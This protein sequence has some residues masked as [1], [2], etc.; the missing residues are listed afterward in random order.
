MP[1]RTGLRLLFAAVIGLA[2]LGAGYGFV[3]GQATPTFEDHLDAQG[4]MDGDQPVAPPSDGI[5]VITTDSNSW[6]GEQSDGPRARANIVA[7]NPDGTVL[8]Y[9]D[10]HTRYWDVE[11]VQGTQA[12]V[13]YAYADHLEAADCPTDWDHTAFGVD[14]EVWDEYYEFHGNVEACTRNGVDRVNLTTGEVTHVWSTITPGK[15]NSRYHDVDRL[16]DERL[17]V[18]DIYFD[19]VFIVNTETDRIEWTWNASDDFSTDSGG[20]H[21]KDWTHINDV[22]VLDDGRLMV[23][24]RN[25]DQVVFLDRERG[26]LEEWTLGA[27]DDHATLYEQHNPD[28]IPPED[29]GP[30]VVI[31][32]SES[33]RVVE[34]QRTDD[35]GW[36]KTWV[37][38]DVRMQ[39]PRDAA[40][41]S[42][43]HTLITDSNGNRVFEVDRS[44]EVVWS[45][46]IAFPYEAERI[47]PGAT[48]A[49]GPS[50]TSAGIESS[51][52]SF[53]DWA[54]IGIKNALPGKHLN[55]LMYATPVWMGLLEVLALA[56]AGLT[57]VLWLVAEGYWRLVGRRNAAAR[58]SEAD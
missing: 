28:Y 37:W 12:T 35:G 48:K 22:D 51:T 2:L 10:T 1:S 7:F 49:G 39:W 47:G 23:S 15:P 46:N 58:T 16:D 42:N 40:R 11:H 45:V 44:G 41:L 26:L 20:P 43:G 31:G 25:H 57:A 6:L 32:D 38:R 36:E 8:Y 29:G 53:V 4:V 14:R 21:P 54:Q 34:Y 17:V 27:D 13:E 56:L 33:N 55:G 19:R 9:N 52:P 18:A 24:M 3:T 5:T 50:A 30:A